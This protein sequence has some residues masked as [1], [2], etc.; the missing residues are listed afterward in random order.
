MICHQEIVCPDCGS[1]HIRKAGYRASDERRI[2]HPTVL[3]ITK[4]AQD[5]LQPQIKA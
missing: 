4:S 5:W 1:N 3:A 2:S